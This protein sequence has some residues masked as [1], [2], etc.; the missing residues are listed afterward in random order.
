QRQRGPALREVAGFRLEAEVARQPV[1]VAGRQ[2]RHLVEA[3][4]LPGEGGDR[5]RPPEE[6]E[7]DGRAPPG[8]RA[9]AA[10]CY[11]QTPGAKSAKPRVLPTR[12]FVVRGGSLHRAGSRAVCSAYGMSCADPDS[13]TAPGPGRS[14]AASTV[15]LKV[16]WMQKMLASVELCAAPSVMSPAGEPVSVM[17]F[18]PP[19]A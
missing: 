17:V 4:R 13:V 5:H 14:P 18:A 15:A 11:S 1:A 7:D 19:P 12:G 8:S 6:H 10:A 2:V 9:H 3:V 16:G